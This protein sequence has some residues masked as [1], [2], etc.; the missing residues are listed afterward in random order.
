M[1]SDE[2]L[3]QIGCVGVSVKSLPRGFSFSKMD[4]FGGLSVL[5]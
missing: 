2:F 1:K 4:R 3:L 5:S